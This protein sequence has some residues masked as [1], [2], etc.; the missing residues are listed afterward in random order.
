MENVSGQRRQLDG[1]GA[2]A[3]F[4]DESGQP[5]PVVDVWSMPT[6]EAIA[7]LRDVYKTPEGEARFMVAMAK[8]E[9]DGDCYAVDERGRRLSHEE[10][11]RRARGK[12]G[13]RG[14]AEAHAAG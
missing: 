13:S 4:F 3:E 1:V 7:Y 10:S 6:E 11:M 8:G 5:L 14:A 9:I 12:H 2:D